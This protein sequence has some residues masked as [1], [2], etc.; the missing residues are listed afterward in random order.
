MMPV[1][2]TYDPETYHIVVH[3]TGKLTTEDYE[4]YLPEIE[5]LIREH[6]KLSILVIMNDFHGWERGALWE[7]I[8]FDAKHRND[9]ARLALVGDKTWEKWMAKICRPFTSAEIR[10]FESHE[11]DAAEA[12]IGQHDV[13]AAGS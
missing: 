1:T 6:G 13:A 5:K 8:K 10:Y 4:K 7:D 11:R 12:W 3:L 9:V 2:L